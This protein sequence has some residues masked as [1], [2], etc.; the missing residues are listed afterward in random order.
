MNTEWVKSHCSWWQ[1]TDLSCE[2][3]A[4]EDTV[5]LT[6]LTHRNTKTCAQ[7][8]T[9]LHICVCLSVKVIL[10]LTGC[11]WLSGPGTGKEETRKSIDLGQ[12]DL[13]LQDDVTG[14]VSTGS[15]EVVSWS[16]LQTL[17]LLTNTL[18]ILSAEILW[19]CWDGNR[20]S[21]TWQFDF[22]HITAWRLACHSQTDAFLLIHWLQR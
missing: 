15:G 11:D 19:R 5:Q 3:A 2:Q 20:Y 13:T 9:D 17:W 7:C 12:P 10:W 4:E 21:F 22:T 18:N 6:A 16:V 14:E 8:L 1:E